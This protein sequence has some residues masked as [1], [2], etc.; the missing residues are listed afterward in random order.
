MN[1]SFK[2]V[3]SGVVIGLFVLIVIFALTGSATVRS[4]NG[5]KTRFVMLQVGVVVRVQ[6][7]CAAYL[8]LETV[9]GPVLDEARHL[10]R[11]V[12]LPFGEGMT[13]PISSAPFSGDYRE[14]WLTA[15]AYNVGPDGKPILLGIVSKSWSVDVYNGTR[16]DVWQIGQ[17]GPDGK[18]RCPFY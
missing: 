13:V 5:T 2:R 8:T 9:E 4:A 11:P 3:V 14:L 17:I 7:A 15:K 12:E 16:H 6:N 18:P 1:V 10:R